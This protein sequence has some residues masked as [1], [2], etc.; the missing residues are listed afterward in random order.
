LEASIVSAETLILKR[1]SAIL[2]PSPEKGCGKDYNRIPMKRMSRIIRTVPQ[3]GKET[4]RK[5][6]RAIFFSSSLLIQNITALLP[7]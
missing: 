3:T 4:M 6:I 2:F 7:I 5:A 1:E